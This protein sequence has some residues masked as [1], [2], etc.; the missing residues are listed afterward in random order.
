MT[1]RVSC[2]LL[3][4]LCA[5][6]HAE[7][8]PPARV[9]QNQ[10]HSFGGNTTLLI[11]HARQMG[12]DYVLGQPWSKTRAQAAK[13]AGLAVL[14]NSNKEYPKYVRL[15]GAATRY[16]VGS[17]PLNQGWPVTAQDEANFNQMFCMSQGGLI[18]PLKDRFYAWKRTAT[19]IIFFANM[20]CQE[21]APL[22]VEYNR[23]LFEDHGGT[24]IFEGLFIDGVGEPSS[25]SSYWYLPCSNPCLDTANTYT[26]RQGE[27]EYIRQMEAYFIGH[28]GLDGISGNPWKIP[29]YMTAWPTL[30]L[31]LLYNENGINLPASWGNV[32]AAAVAVQMPY[33]SASS[34][35][36]QGGTHPLDADYPTALSILGPAGIKGAWFGWYGESIVEKST[37]STQLARALPNWD[38]LVGA[39]RRTWDAASL[40][41]QSTNSYADPNVIYGRHAKTGKIFA[42]FQN[43]QGILLLH[44]GEV[45]T[46]VQ[47]VDAIFQASGDGRSQLVVDGAQVTMLDTANAGK[48]YILTTGE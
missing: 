31:D 44:A 35:P 18:R 38:N 13:A 37:N 29:Q 39:T 9:F 10:L 19:E 41:Y 28:L 12:Y 11:H 46:D 4:L 25:T 48:G 14:W 40:R 1:T 21:T 34:V 16:N 32:P 43:T 27:L 20:Q 2:L 8:P 23:R 36:G 17:G 45:V 47:R 15:N 6:A 22:L 3:V 33:G 5:T 30:P 24:D 7:C 26:Q 42:V